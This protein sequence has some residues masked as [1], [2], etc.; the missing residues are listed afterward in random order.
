MAE[1]RANIFGFW[2]LFYAVGTNQRETKLSVFAGEGARGEAL[3]ED[4]KNDQP[5]R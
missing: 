2:R 1:W 5:P 4:P 3:H